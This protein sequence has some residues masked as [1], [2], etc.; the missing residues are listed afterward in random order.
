MR[1]QRS[2]DEEGAQGRR[3]GGRE[4][5][6]SSPKERRRAHFLTLVFHFFIR[7]KAERRQWTKPNRQQQTPGMAVR[8]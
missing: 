7:I 1:I 5:T 4:N 3:R 6:E 2:G 8:E